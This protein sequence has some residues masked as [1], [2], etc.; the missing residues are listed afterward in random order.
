MSGRGRL[1]A[2]IADHYNDTKVTS[3]NSTTFADRTQRRIF[4]ERL[5]RH[6]AAAALGYE[7]GRFSVRLNVR[8][9]GPWTDRSGNANGDIFPCFGSMVSVN[10]DI[11]SHV[12]RSMRAD[13]S[14]VRKQVAFPAR[15]CRAGRIHPQRDRSF[16]GNNRRI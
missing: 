14:H 11:S 15:R 10:R 5:R 13:L 7:L 12:R 9:Y 6:N 8:Y 4:E 16:E 3:E 1:G 2:S